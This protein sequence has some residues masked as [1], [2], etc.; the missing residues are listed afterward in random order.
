MAINGY[1]GC[2]MPVPSMAVGERCGCRLASDQLPP[3]EH[4]NTA[5][6]H[7]WAV[8]GI[9]QLQHSPPTAACSCLAAAFP[10]Q[11]HACCLC[12]RRVRWYV[13]ALGSEEAIHVAHWHGIALEAGGHHMDQIIVQGSELHVLDSLID[14]PGGRIISTACPARCR[15]CR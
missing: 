10:P 11:M 7:A 15:P 5:G 4:E 6:H 8:V 1:L 13:G 14:N 9:A 12:P 2:N 3:Y